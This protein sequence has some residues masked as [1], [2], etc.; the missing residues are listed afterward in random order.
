MTKAWGPLG[1]ATLHTIAALYP[2]FPSQYE[3]EL[4]NRFLESFTQTILC[5]SCL[6]HFSDMVTVY[7][8]RNPG[9]KNSRHTVCEFV[10]R[11]HN[12]VNQRTHKKMYTLEESIELLRTIM[13]D[14]QAARVK[15]QQ[16]LVYI[17]NDWMKNM[18]LNGI[19]SAPKLKELNTIEE[20][21]WSKRS[22]SWSDIASFTN[23]SIS[24]IPERS[25]ATSSGDTIIPKITMPV[26]GGFKLK[27]IGK[28]GPLSS[29]RSR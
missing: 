5:P 12:T 6:Q 24:P 25:S 28:I 15:R 19:S 2:D 20:E 18:T 16:Y 14:Y 10:F 23:I 21:Y 9:W 13:P 27:N 8:Q 4:L 1:W 17:R 26:S 22:F 11:A 7:T 29:L 3:L